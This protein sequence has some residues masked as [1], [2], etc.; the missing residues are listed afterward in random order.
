MATEEEKEEDIEDQG[1][2]SKKGS[3]TNGSI[4]FYPP[5]HKKKSS[6]K[7]FVIVIVVIILLAGG[8][9]LRNRIKGVVK[10]EPEPT[11]TPS[12]TSIPTPESN[13]LVRSDWS[14]EVLNGTSS[15]GLAKALADK[16][17]ALGY[18]VVKLGNADKD[19]YTRTEILVKKNLMA[20]INLV[21]ADLK[22]TVKIASLA[23]ELNEG[24]ASARIIIGKDLTF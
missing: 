15:S 12:V 7:V 24:S 3:D 16:L 23:G 8:F 11:P 6:K 13:P 14:F 19:T 20:K 22:D 5:P 10:Q 17:I 9:L 4:A 21:V 2:E 1:L 18:P